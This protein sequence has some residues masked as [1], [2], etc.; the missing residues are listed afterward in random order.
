M[1]PQEITNS[2]ALSTGIVIHHVESE[3]QNG[4][5]QIHVLIPDNYGD[6][7]SDHRVLYVLP[8]EKSGDCRRGYPLDVL[9]HMDAHNRYGL[10][11]VFVTIQEEPWFV[12]HA[13][14]RKVRQASY[15]H[16]FV[17][18]Y[19][20]RIYRTVRG[21]DGRFL[22]GFSK[23]GW[24]GYRLIFSRPDMYGFAAAWDAP[25]LVDRFI[26]E[27]EAAIGT[28]AQLTLCRPDLAVRSLHGSFRDQSRLVLAGENAFGKLVPPPVGDSHVIEMHRLLQKEGI[29]HTYLEEIG[30]PHTF[31]RAWME[32]TLSALMDLA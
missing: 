20:D 31:N 30:C 3:F 1:P 17:V 8:V 19:V 22:F 7:G 14:D 5:Q 13:V 16:E 21:P 9:R 2:A 24:G 27:M 26:Y 11:I 15:M 29:H 25:F 28:T 23:G 32:P 6:S 10:L 12:D 18:P 4:G